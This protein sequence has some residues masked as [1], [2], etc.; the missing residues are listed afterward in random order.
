MCLDR[1]EGMHCFF[2]CCVFWV[3]QVAV[4]PH[5]WVCLTQ[6]SYGMAYLQSWAVFVHIRMHN[7]LLGLCCVDDILAGKTDRAFCA[8]RPPGHHAEV[9]AAMG[10]CIFNN[11]A[12]AAEIALTDPTIER[13][14]IVDFDVH[15]GNGTV[16]I[17]KNDERVMVCSSFQHPFYPNR[18]YSLKVNNW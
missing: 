8:I 6:A 7:S 12:L 1:L 17:F 14:A 2:D 11:I 3:Q 5:F 4:I 10:F 18:H 16:D 13:V 15:N 9:A